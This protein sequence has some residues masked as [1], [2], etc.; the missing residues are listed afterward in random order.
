LKLL[1]LF[2]SLLALDQSTKFLVRNTMMLGQSIPVL[3]QVFKITYVENPGIAFGL[4]VAHGSVFTLLSILASLFIV[5]LLFTHRNE[6]PAFKAALVM[7]LSG[8][9]GNLIDRLL[10]SHVADFI[11]VGIRNLR[12]YVFNIADSAVVVGML[13]MSYLIF[14]SDPKT[15]K[16]PAAE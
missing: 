16:Q 11:D 7:I 5:V 8:A 15:R 6:K 10:F 4:R 2:S 12:W 13:I 3:G 1:L 14:I 9:V